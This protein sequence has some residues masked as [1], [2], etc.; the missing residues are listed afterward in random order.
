[1]QMKYMLWIN[2]KLFQYIFFEKVVEWRGRTRVQ[3]RRTRGDV[4]F[5]QQLQRF[6]VKEANGGTLGERHPHSAA[7]ARHVC[8]ADHRLW[9]DFKLLRWT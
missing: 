4:D 1:M 9:M 7:S 8:N 5:L 6:C 3:Q 2:N